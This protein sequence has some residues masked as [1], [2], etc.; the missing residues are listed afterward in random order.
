MNGL[1]LT[2]IV[3]GLWVG[4]AALAAMAFC[5]PRKPSRRRPF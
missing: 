2:A 5:R 1:V 3:L 4:L